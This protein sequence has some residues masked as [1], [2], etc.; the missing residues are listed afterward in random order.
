[1]EWPMA[2]VA[3]IWSRKTFQRKQKFHKTTVDINHYPYITS[4]GGIQNVIHINA[5]RK[6]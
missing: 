6:L 5:A 3:E 4:F 1:M 2:N